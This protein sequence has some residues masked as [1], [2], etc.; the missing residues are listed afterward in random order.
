MSARLACLSSILVSL[1]ALAQHAEGSP[2]W[3]YGGAQGPTHW[4][5]LSGDFSEC[6]KGQQQSPVDI[7]HETPADLPPIQ[8]NYVPS[9]LRIIDNGHTIEVMVAPGSSI[10]VGDAKYELQQFHFHHPA[11][12]RIH[13][14]SFP[15][16]AHLVHKSAEG[17]L[18]VVAVLFKHGAPNAF[19]KGLWKNMPPDKGVE[20]APEGVTFDLNQL[21][22]K[23][24]G[25]YTFS[26]SLTTP[27]CSEQVTW[28][29]LKTQ[30][31][32]S[33]DGEAAFVKKYPHNAR[34]VQPLYGRSVL[35]TK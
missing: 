6:A 25:Y 29:V 17:K 2:S 12:E 32:M 23:D 15:L 4:G 34:P 5:Q 20:H 35:A 30:A 3:T 9:P 14:K 8:F 18:A 21:L 22:P 10:Q 27:P 16:V 28:F 19:L 7:Q 1:P 24:R 26:G 31:E 11:E 33:K 13:G